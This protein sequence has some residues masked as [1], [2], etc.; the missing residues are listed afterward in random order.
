MYSYTNHSAIPVLRRLNVQEA[1]LL[2]D[3]MGGFG[4]KL[5]WVALE[6]R[7]LITVLVKEV[8]KIKLSC[9]GH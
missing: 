8:S 4:L 9:C 1:K 6:A 5:L 7:Q 3:G 2:K